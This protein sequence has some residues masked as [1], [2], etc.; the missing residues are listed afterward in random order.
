MYLVTKHLSWS[1]A[2]GDLAVEWVSNTTTCPEHDLHSLVIENNVRLP[3]KG[4][5]NRYL[6]ESTV[7]AGIPPDQL[8]HPFLSH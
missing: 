4:R 6:F 1:E 8:V 2:E 3:N 7:F 5:I